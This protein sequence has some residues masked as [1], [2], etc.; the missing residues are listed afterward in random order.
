MGKVMIKNG[1]QQEMEE[2][3]DHQKAIMEIIKKQRT[4]L[5]EIQEN[6]D[7]LERRIAR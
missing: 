6:L 3:D 4:Q 2:V 1:S 7:E 5:A